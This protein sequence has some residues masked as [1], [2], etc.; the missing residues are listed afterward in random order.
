VETHFFTTLLTLQVKIITLDGAV[1]YN[2]GGHPQVIYLLQ[3]CKIVAVTLASEISL[4]SRL[5]VSNY[6]KLK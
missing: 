3:K 6:L 5:H 1:C 2:P 4:R